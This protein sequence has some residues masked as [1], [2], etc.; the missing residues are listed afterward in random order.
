[1]TREYDLFERFSDGSSLWRGCVIGIENTRHHLE[2]LARK[3]KNRFYA[4]DMTAGTIHHLEP[5]RETFA[6]HASKGMEKR[7]S[8]T[9]A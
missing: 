8:A 5:G 2:Q 6:L 1:M 3:S 4:I 9:V 7:R